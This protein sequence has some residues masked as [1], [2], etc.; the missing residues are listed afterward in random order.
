MEVNSHILGAYHVRTFM[1]VWFKM[2]FMS[3]D[4]KFGNPLIER[5][6]KRLSLPNRQC[7]DCNEQ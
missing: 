5:L 1:S 2:G 4:V 6:C 7:H 3:F